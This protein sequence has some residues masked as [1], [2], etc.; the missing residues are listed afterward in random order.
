MPDDYVG[1]FLLLC[2]KCFLF[3][4]N[5]KIKKANINVGFFAAIAEPLL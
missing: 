3:S 2:M 5:Q 1:H 4:K